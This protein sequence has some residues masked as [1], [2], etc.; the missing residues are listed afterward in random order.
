MTVSKLAQ[1]LRIPS[2]E[3]ILVLNAPKGYDEVLQPLPGG[4]VVCKK[5]KG[6]FAF[7]HVFAKDIA[8][9]ERLAP[10]ALDALEYDG[11]CWMSYPK[12]TS[13]L[14]SD[15]NRDRGWDV[16]RARGLRGVSQVSIDDTWS[17]LRF[18]PV[19]EVKSR[20]R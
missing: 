19:K 12:G 2:G 5:G 10:R 6:P 17:A 3:R 16:L 1:K 9:L 18:R 8:D 7:V 14:K 15:I 20:R 13:T 4:A 11:V